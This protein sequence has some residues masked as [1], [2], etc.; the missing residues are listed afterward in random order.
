[1]E[2]FFLWFLIAK[3]SQLGRLVYFCFFMYFFRKLLLFSVLFSAV[4]LEAAELKV[5][6]SVVPVYSWTVAVGGS[7]AKVESLSDGSVDPHE[8]QLTPSGVRKLNNAD[9]VVCIGLELEPWLESMEENGALSK[10]VKVVKLGECLDKKYLLRMGDEG[11]EEDH[12]SEDEEHEGHH[13]HGIYDPHIWMDPVLAQE[14][15]K[16]IAAQLGALDKDHAEDFGKNA[17]AYTKRLKQLDEDIRT[18][19]KGVHLKPFY[20]QHEAFAY[21]NKRYGLSCAGVLQEV[22]NSDV[23]PRHLAKL[24]K[25][26][27][28]EKVVAIMVPRKTED[29][30]VQRI[31][32]DG[33][34]KI[35][36]LETLGTLDD[37]KLD[38]EAYERMLRYNLK[39]M[40]ESLQ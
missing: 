10:L 2:G 23:S 39:V 11:K 6:T 38:V 18:G 35:G 30:L 9:V 29:R 37:G 20:V 8:F 12:D 33:K 15:V 4:L 22:P 13:H 24:M 5:V 17:A 36:H 3:G 31:A 28:E 27:Q 25:K 21:F 26:I 34:L 16:V 32:A 40:L 1:M 19:L 14:C 7:L